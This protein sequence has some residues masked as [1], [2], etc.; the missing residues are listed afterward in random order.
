MKEESLIN[1]NKIKEENE[2]LKNENAILHDCLKI[3]FT[4][5]EESDWMRMQLN[6][7]IIRQN[8]I[9]I[10]EKIDLKKKNEELK[11]ENECFKDCADTLIELQQKYSLLLK[12]N[13]KPKR[14]NEFCSCKSNSTEYEISGWIDC[15]CSWCKTV[16]SPELIKFLDKKYKVI[17]QLEE[18]NAQLKAQVQKIWEYF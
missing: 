9:L 1:F 17:N 5:P 16:C 10:N 2:K 4:L 3:V 18:E 12:E 15:D 8:K 13:E 14:E 7:L 11:A 6:D